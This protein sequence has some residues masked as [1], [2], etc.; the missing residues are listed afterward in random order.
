MTRTNVDF[1]L[2]RELEWKV[3]AENGQC[4]LN[5]YR[6]TNR[7][8]GVPGARY[9]EGWVV[10]HDAPVPIEHGWLE[11][12]DGTIVD[13]TPVYCN[14]TDGRTYHGAYYWTATELTDHCIAILRAGHRVTLPLWE[15]LGVHDPRHLAAARVQASIPQL[16]PVA[17][18]REPDARAGGDAA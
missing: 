8:S 3:E 13:P 12:P 9:V 4:Y 17:E 14:R 11:M 2:S 16:A 15:R 1:Q 18:R 10:W 6:A 5:A 7:L